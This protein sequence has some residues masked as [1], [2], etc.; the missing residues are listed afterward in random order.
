[1][2]LSDKDLSRL[3]GHSLFREVPREL[4]CGVLESCGE[5]VRE[6]APGERICCPEDPCRKA[7]LM[8][9]GKATVTTPDVS[10]TVLLRV[11][12]PGSLF[13][14]A[15]LFSDEPFVSL[16]RADSHC[17]CVI[18]AESAI[19][20]LL[21]ASSSFRMRYI[22]FLSDRIRFL[23]RKIGYLTAGSAERRLALYLASLGPGEVRLTDSITS[24]SDLLN[25]GRASLYRAFDRLC[26]DGYLTRNGRNLTIPDP[27]AMLNAYQ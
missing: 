5:G 19:A 20:R 13:G 4:L 15:N 21:D 24:L 26:A 8:L 11:L 25:L 22:G 10:R 6:Y 14:V 17:R 3:C 7:G 1:M 12:A 9:S 2:E 16:I 27:A 23:N 18:F